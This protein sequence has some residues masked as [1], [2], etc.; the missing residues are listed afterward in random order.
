MAHSIILKHR[1]SGLVKRGFYGFSWT[2]LFFGMFPALF[3]AD[4]L[5][6]IGGFVVLALLGVMTMGIYSL[7]GMFVWAFLYNRYYTRKL[8]ERGYTFMDS[9]GAVAEARQRLGVAA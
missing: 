4:F 9:E 3:R 8:L 7:V 2:T 1:D 6:F 5:T